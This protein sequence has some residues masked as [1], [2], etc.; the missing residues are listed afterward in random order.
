M[1]FPKVVIKNPP[2]MW[3]PCWLD[4]GKKYCPICKKGKNEISNSR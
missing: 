4:V 1:K 2:K 3:S